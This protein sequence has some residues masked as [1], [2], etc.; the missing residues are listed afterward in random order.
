MLGGDAVERKQAGRGK[1]DGSLT[2]TGRIY[3]GSKIGGIPLPLE[4]QEKTK[5]L[6]LPSFFAY[7]KYLPGLLLNSTGVP[8]SPG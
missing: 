3:I 2:F 7:L 1:Q 5:S 8:D 6:G 4:S